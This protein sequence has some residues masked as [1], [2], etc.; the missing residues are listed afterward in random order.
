MGAVPGP[1]TKSTLRQHVALA[2]L[3][4][5]QAGPAQTK[6]REFEVSMLVDKQVIWLQVTIEAG[7]SESGCVNFAFFDQDSPMNHTPFV[8]VLQA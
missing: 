8:Q 7:K 4:T 5:Q 2:C 3:T 6:V 1:V